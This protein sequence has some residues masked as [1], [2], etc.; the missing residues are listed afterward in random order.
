MRSMYGTPAI[1]SDWVEPIGSAVAPSWQP[2][3]SREAAAKPA[4]DPMPFKA[5]RRLIT[6][7]P[8]LRS[9]VR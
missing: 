5:S 7:V 4:N 9:G 1:R 8:F 2:G 3:R 6:I